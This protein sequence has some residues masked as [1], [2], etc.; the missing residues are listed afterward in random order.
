M[1]EK[2]DAIVLRYWPSSNTS[3][4]VAWLTRDF[5]RVHTMIKGAMRPKSLF[6]GQYDL[7]YTCELL[8]YNHENRDLVFAKECA[9]LQRRDRFRNDWRAMCCASYP[10]DTIFHICPQHTPHPELFALLT[11]VLD[12]ANAM[13]GSPQLLFW[14]ELRLLEQLGQAPS[15]HRCVQCTEYVLPSPRPVYFSTT[16]GGVICHQCYDQGCRAVP[17]SQSVWTLMKQIDHQSDPMAAALIYAP[18]DPLQQ[19][20]RLLRQFMTHHVDLF[21]ECRDISMRIL[22]NKSFPLDE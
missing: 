22:F 16:D 2:T 18:V 14:F 6:L 4:V 1:I 20:S 17:L 10:L 13:G 9:P 11:H 3:R 12:T 5:G 19:L 21:P 8:F 7:F 15:L